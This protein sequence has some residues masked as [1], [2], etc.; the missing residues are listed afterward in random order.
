MDMISIESRKRELE[1]G[2]YPQTWS[3]KRFAANKGMREN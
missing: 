2:I 3:E 1:K